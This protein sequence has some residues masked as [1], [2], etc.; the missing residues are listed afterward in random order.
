MAASQELT[1]QVHTIIRTAIGQYYVTKT[2]ARG[3]ARANI[4]PG[5]VTFIQRFGSAMNLNLHFHVVFLEGVYVD[6]TAQGLQPRFV[7]AEPPTDVDITAVVQKIS[8]RIIRMLRR[9]G[10][11]EA[12]LDAPVATSYDPLVDDAPELAR[13]LAASPCWDWARLLKRVFA[14]DMARCPFC[15]QG[16]LRIIAAMTQGEVIR[17]ILQPLKLSADPPP[18]T[19]ARVRQEAF[20][21]SSA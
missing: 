13:T 19:A 3:F 5:S 20:A 4:Y 11:L 14:L 8:H 16:T 6:R 15:Q 17:K 9:M 2:V 10:Y 7:K 21:W 1:A 18:I 12:D